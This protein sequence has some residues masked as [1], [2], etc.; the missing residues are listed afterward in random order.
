MDTFLRVT[1]GVAPNPGPD[2][3]F[4]VQKMKRSSALRVDVVVYRFEA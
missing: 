1:L 2:L 3:G 4:R